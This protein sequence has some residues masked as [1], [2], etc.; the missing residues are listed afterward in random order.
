MPI[1]T[2]GVPLISGAAN[3]DLTGLHKQQ[4]A[5]QAFAL[6]LQQ[7]QFELEQEKQAAAQREEA[8]KAREQALPALIP[9]ELQ[10]QEYGPPAPTAGARVEQ[11]QLRQKQ[12]EMATKLAPLL[13]KLDNETLSRVFQEMH[14]MVTREEDQMAR[15]HAAEYL[16]RLGASFGGEKGIPPEIQQ[17][18][19]GFKQQL[20]D[21]KADPSAIIHQAQQLAAPKLAQEMDDQRAMLLASK[22]EAALSQTGK[23]PSE[24]AHQQII[25][26]QHGVGD[27][28]FFEQNFDKI[29][30]GLEPVGNLWV[31]SD[32]APEVRKQMAQA[33]SDK[34][35]LAQANAELAQMKAQYEQLRPQIE[36]DKNASA[37]ADR[38]ENLKLRARSIDV[39]QGNLDERKREGAA[40]AVSRGENLNL[41]KR[42]AERGSMKDALDAAQKDPAWADAKTQAEQD[43]IIEKYRTKLQPKTEAKLTPEERARQ[44]LNKP[45]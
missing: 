36:R 9:P 31:S 17:V 16:D 12:V 19:D 8:R 42:N 38:G 11:D 20:Q 23:L 43:A 30:A 15:K 25:A 10:S 34:N 2:T 21:P 29:M 39:Q 32:Q 37:A 5:D 35:A 45:K 18:V 4:Q 28:K 24:Y 27:T 13:G 14:G 1:I 22:A 3:A 41:G 7:A 33:V 40:A 44:F 26:L 6:K